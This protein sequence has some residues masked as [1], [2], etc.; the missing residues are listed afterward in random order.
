[1]CVQKKK[2]IENKITNYIHNDFNYMSYTYKIKQE[3]QVTSNFFNL[4]NKLAI[5]LFFFLLCYYY[6]YYYYYYFILYHQNI[7]F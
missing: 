1:M 6:D 5:K 4:I 3:I 7:K 2:K